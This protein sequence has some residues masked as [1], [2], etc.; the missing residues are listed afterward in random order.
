MKDQVA[1]RHAHAHCAVVSFCLFSW[2]RPVRFSFCRFVVLCFAFASFAYQPPFGLFRGVLWEF[3]PPC[4]FS[5]LCFLLRSLWFFDWVVASEAW[6]FLF[7]CLSPS[8]P[9]CF[10]LFVSSHAHKNWVWLKDNPFLGT[11]VGWFRGLV[12]GFV[13]GVCLFCI[14]IEQSDAEREREKAMMMMMMM[15]MIR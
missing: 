14:L 13:G 5:G 15:M 2:L 6:I 3:L 7:F 4:L 10:V 1:G 8:F 12:V 9:L 11:L